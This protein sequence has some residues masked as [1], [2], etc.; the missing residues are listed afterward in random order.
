MAQD[1]VERGRIFGTSKGCTQRNITGTVSLVW[2]QV[3]IK[4]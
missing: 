1:D 4:S 2:Y 3:K